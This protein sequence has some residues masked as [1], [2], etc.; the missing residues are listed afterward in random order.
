M[1]GHVPRRRLVACVDDFL[2]LSWGG[3]LNTCAVGWSRQPGAPAAADPDPM[4]L[5][6]K[7]TVQVENR[8]L[9]ISDLTKSSTRR[10]D[11]PRAK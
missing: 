1:P 9:T 2:Q 4:P 7:V 10:P 5:G 8:R 11:S 3:A 6:D